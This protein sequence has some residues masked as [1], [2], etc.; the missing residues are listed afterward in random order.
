M[1]LTEKFTSHIAAAHAEYESARRE[2]SK[3]SSDVL[4]ASKRAIFALQ[5]GDEKSADE[6]L[7][8]AA[9]SIAMLRKTFGETLSLDEEGAYRAALEEYAEALLV[10]VFVRKDAKSMEGLLDGFDYDIVIAALSDATGELQRLQV[11]AA[12]DGRTDDVAELAK[13]IEDIVAFLTT[14]DFHG[15]LRTK[16][17][18][19]KNS[20]RRAE[21]VLYE[22]KLRSR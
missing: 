8:A 10:R 22:V 12:I 6:M 14:M 16:Y 5:R 3:H 2:V 1:L 13:A 7:A 19:A 4:A 15:Y 9:S 11:K 17:D 21:D 20:L 18:Q